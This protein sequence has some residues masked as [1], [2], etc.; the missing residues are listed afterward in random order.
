[1]FK[2]VRS[3]IGFLLGVLTTG[4]LVL[5]VAGNTQSEL[6]AAPD[7]PESEPSYFLRKIRGP[8][9]EIDTMSPRLISP[10]EKESH[11]P[12]LSNCLVLP[13]K[14]DYTNIRPYL[15]AMGEM[16]FPAQEDGGLTR[17]VTDA[18]IPVEHAFRRARMCVGGEADLASATH[19]IGEHIRAM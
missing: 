10:L 14:G 9:I 3:I 2:V 6:R 18:R 19:R 5:L 16:E 8:G 4:G 7:E 15:D 11:E 12:P 13:G 1:M 17:E